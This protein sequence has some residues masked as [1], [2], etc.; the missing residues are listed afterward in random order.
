MFHNR[1]EVIERAIRE[2]KLLD[3]LV[4]GL[5]DKDWDR[6]LPRPDT[7]DPWTVKDALAHITHWE[8]DVARSAGGQV[9]LEE[10]GLVTNEAEPPHLP[11][12][13]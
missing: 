12:M 1:D 4:T 9:P 10:R 3:H 8:A 5:S 6:F 7:K 11:A 2:F 13:A